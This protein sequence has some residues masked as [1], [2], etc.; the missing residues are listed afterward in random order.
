MHVHL[1]AQLFAFLDIISIFVF[2]LKMKIKQK[3]G[4]SVSS[5]HNSVSITFHGYQQKPLC[6]IM[7]LRTKSLSVILESFPIHRCPFLIIIFVNKFSNIPT[8]P[9]KQCL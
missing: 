1:E 3:A 7:H 9:L 6:C 4:R 8:D 2:V 5:G